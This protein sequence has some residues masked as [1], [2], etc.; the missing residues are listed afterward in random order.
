METKLELKTIQFEKNC[1]YDKLKFHNKYD[2][3]KNN[4]FEIQLYFQDMSKRSRCL[5]DHGEQN[6]KKAAMFLSSLMKTKAIHKIKICL[7]QDKNQYSVLLGLM[8]SFEHFKNIYKSNTQIQ[9][10]LLANNFNLDENICDHVYFYTMTQLQAFGFS[11]NSTDSVDNYI[12][13][14]TDASY[15]ECLQLLLCTLGKIPA[16]RF[17][18]NPCSYISLLSLCTYKSE[19]VRCNASEYGNYCSIDNGKNALGLFVDDDS[20]EWDLTNTNK[21]INLLHMDLLDILGYE[22]VELLYPE[23]KYSL[24]K[25]CDIKIVN[26]FP[27]EANFSIFPKIL[28]KGLTFHS[29]TGEINGQAQELSDNVL[30]TISLNNSQKNTCI[31]LEIIDAN[32]DPSLLSS[33]ITAIV[34]VLI[35]IFIF[36]VVVCGYKALHW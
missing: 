23:K 25:N 4:K 15:E 17:K 34:I 12:G 19:N 2:S 13:L 36:A 29:E 24:V 14:T 18:N 8:S 16:F 9:K 31:E 7:E 11:N 33:F 27:F 20:L 1:F 22:T 10:T 32:V 30:Y 28:P 35:L 21:N 26:N 6:M 5:Y 3:F